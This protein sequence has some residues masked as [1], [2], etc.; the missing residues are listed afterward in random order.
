[1][2]SFLRS[3]VL[4]IALFS[5]ATVVHA[6]DSSEVSPL[7]KFADVAQDELAK[8]TG[9]LSRMREEIAAEKLPLAQE[10][11]TSED[12]VIELRRELEK[13]N[14][15]VDSGNLGIVNTKQEIKARQDEL[16]YI[17]NLLDEYVRSFESKLIIGELQSLGDKIEN[18]KQATENTAFTTDERFEI[19]SALVND[20]I[21]RLNEAI[22]GMVIEGTAVDLQGNVENGKY[23]LVG[24]VVLFKSNT[25]ATAGI[26]IP[27]TGSPNPLVRPIED[28]ALQASLS[29]LVS[30]G[31]G[32]MPF[33]PTR[34]GALKAM[35]QKTDLGHIFKE[36]GPIMWPLLISAIIA[37]LTVLERLIFLAIQSFKRDPKAQ[38]RFFAA[39]TA[40]NL[41]EA[42]AISKKTSFYLVRCLGYALEHKE[43]SLANALLYA[44]EKELKRFRRG[45]PI[46]DTIITLAPLLGLLGTVT[47]MMASFALIG[48]ELSAPG[49][50][51]GGIAEAL[52]ATA[53]GLGIAIVSLIPFN[54]LNTKMDEARNEIEAAA[55]L[56]ELLVHPTETEM[57]LDQDEPQVALAK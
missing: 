50:I 12:Q 33:D 23:A 39:V 2:K 20:S 18:A 8:S 49:A 25:N 52:I 13:L 44:Q 7:K 45:I 24:P 27:Q 54:Y 30:K 57:L 21:A 35:V 11:T 29:E 5:A 56:V 42:V 43:K 48:G 1:M 32:F 10:L 19:Q 38:A 46:L 17:G 15:L 14:R 55:R 53:F 40:G 37:I 34:G 4:T 47:G 28:E 26:V 6:Q 9:E 41:D 16:D 3:F 22:G 51:T 36:G 31:E